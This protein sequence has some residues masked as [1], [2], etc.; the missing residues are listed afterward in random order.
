MTDALKNCPLCDG[1]AKLDYARVGGTGS[2]GMETPE[3]FIQCTTCFLKTR[4][5]RC[6]DWPYGKKDGIPT[7]KQAVAALIEYWNK[8]P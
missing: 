4:I 6:T 1:P 8:R 2:S 5:F 3:P 7:Q